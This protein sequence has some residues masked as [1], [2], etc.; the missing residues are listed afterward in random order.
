M[1]EEKRIWKIFKYLIL[2]TSAYII[3]FKFDLSYLLENLSVYKKQ[4]HSIVR[5]AFEFNLKRNYRSCEFNIPF[6]FFKKSLK[7]DLNFEEFHENSLKIIK[8]QKHADLDK[9]LLHIKEIFLIGRN[10]TIKIAMS[11]IQYFTWN[12]Q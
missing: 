1:E 2:K 3:F 5:L 7:N 6:I 11:L 8:K 4:Y 10:V 12:I 9:K